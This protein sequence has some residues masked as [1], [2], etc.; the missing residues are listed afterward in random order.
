M[1]QVES[2]M[3]D[4]ESHWETPNSFGEGNPFAGAELSEKELSLIREQGMSVEN[5]VARDGLTE[6]YN[7]KSPEAKKVFDAVLS[8]A[9]R[10]N[11]QVCFFELDLDHFKDFND[12]YGHPNGDKVLRAM[13]AALGK[14]FSRGS[15]LVGRNGGEEFVGMLIGIKLEDVARKLQELARNYREE[16]GALAK[17]DTAFPKGVAR[18]LTFSAGVAKA[19]L[20]EGFSGGGRGMVYESLDAMEGRADRELYRAKGGVHP[21]NPQFAQTGRNAVSVEGNFELIQLTGK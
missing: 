15:D 21:E 9:G 13:A 19:R 16:V 17:E 1:E 11:T 12:S 14:T 8:E 10:S 18:E 20:L 2:G 4:I 6:I 5:R 7:F 3:T